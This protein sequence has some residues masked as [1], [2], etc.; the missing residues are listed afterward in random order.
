MERELRVF[1]VAVVIGLVGL[2]LLTVAFL[3]GDPS[4]QRWP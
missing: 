4:I 3:V 1:A 2:A